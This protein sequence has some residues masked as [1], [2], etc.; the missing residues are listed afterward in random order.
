MPRSDNYLD[1]N[2][3]KQLVVHDEADERRAVAAAEDFCGRGAT[4]LQTVPNAL[5]L[6]RVSTSAA[7]C[8]PDHVPQES[9]VALGERRAIAQ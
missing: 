1:S 3:R 2:G 5:L 7:G 6:H 4:L 8:D 9:N